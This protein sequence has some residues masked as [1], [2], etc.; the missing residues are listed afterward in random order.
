MITKCM[1]MKHWYDDTEDV[2]HLFV[3]ARHVDS[4]CTGVCFG[5]GCIVRETAGGLGDGR[6]CVEVLGGGSK[7]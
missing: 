6:Q 2:E 3:D 7:T 4:I 5:W 1:D